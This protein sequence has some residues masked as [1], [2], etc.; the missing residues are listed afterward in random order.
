MKSP[1][2]KPTKVSAALAAARIVRPKSYWEPPEA[3]FTAPKLDELKNIAR[4]A[5]PDIDEE[6]LNDLLMRTAFAIED[7]CAMR[8]PKRH[9]LVQEKLAELCEAAATFLLAW[10]GIR[11]DH[12]LLRTVELHF[13]GL[14]FS[15]PQP[16]AKT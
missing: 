8:E 16:P 11:S 1:P 12:Q 6:A 4:R 3:K 2:R 10:R 5:R 14:L 15:Q 13:Q 9:N 7:L